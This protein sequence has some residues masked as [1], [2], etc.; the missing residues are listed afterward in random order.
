MN[1]RFERDE[2]PFD[3]VL[4]SISCGEKFHEC[5]CKL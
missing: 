4:T 3:E 2:L 1:L 5:W